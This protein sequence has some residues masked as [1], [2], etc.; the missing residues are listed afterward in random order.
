MLMRQFGEPVVYYPDGGDTGRS[1]T[2]IVNRN[3]V[4]VISE[5]GEV[6][7]RLIEVRVRNDDKLGISSTEID[8]GAD[9]IRLPLRVGESSQRRQITE[10][11]STE[12]GLVRFLIQ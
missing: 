6:H 4:E 8:T 10:V 12:N 7:A 2:A 11:L 9:E 5:T 3:G 1:I